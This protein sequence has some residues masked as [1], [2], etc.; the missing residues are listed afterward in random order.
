MPVIQ[1]PSSFS[2]LA[3]NIDTGGIV[4]RL[5]QIE[6][7]PETQLDNNIQKV[8]QTKAAW[9]GVNGALLNLKVAGDAL[10]DTSLWSS[11]GATVSDQ[12]AAA[13]SA[14][15]SAAAG[16]YNITI[17][18]LARAESDISGS[19]GSETNALG[20]SGT[21]S[22]TVGG[23]AK[24][25]T[26]ATTDSLDS[27]RDKINKAGAGVTATVVSTTPGTFALLVQA[28]STGTASA[29]AFGDDATNHTLRSLGLLT[30]ADAKNAVQAAQDAQ[31]SI[32]GLTF[33]RSSNT[34]TDAITGVTLSL[35]ALNT[36]GFT[37]TVQSDTATMS[38]RI[39]DFVS[40]F[41]ATHATISQLTGQGAL[42]QG[43]SALNGIASQLATL[44]YNTV[45]GLS[46]PNNLSQIGVT[47]QRDGTLAVD[48]VTLNKA[49]GDNLT[50]VKALFTTATSVTVARFS[51]YLG[52]LTRSTGTLSA[53][54]QSFDSQVQDM[55]RQ[56]Q[57]MEVALNLRQETLKAQFTA[58]EVAVHQF[59]AQG[60]WLSSQISG[61]SGGASGG[62]K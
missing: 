26:V 34:V 47:L 2:G 13:A 54:S 38:S 42:L 31:F 50:G 57:A 55:Q 30:G 28:N 19:F 51:T 49:L 18:H 35:K 48:S 12:T 32:N 44:S 56:R 24:S 4:E 39:Q 40:R 21:F 23:T 10:G 33:T 61:L 5:M 22:L 11:L 14:N 58:M 36:T 46:G 7:A 20:L 52:G 29:I 16:T 25:V 62:G 6:R 8:Q 17:D 41:N 3:S 15:A 1:P 27:L 60:N 59:Q 37:L 43:D 9:T 53:L 45:S